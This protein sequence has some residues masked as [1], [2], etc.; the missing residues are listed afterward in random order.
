MDKPTKLSLA[1]IAAVIVAL[2]GGY[3]GA[4]FR[5]ADSASAATKAGSWI[6]DIKSRGELRVGVA[7]APP[8]TVE[9]NGVLGGP[10]LIPLQHLAKTLGVKLTPVPAT[11]GNIVAGLQAGRYDAAANLDATLERAKAIQFSDSVYEY[12]GV[13]VIAANSPYRTSKDVIAS[14]KQVAV[15][16]G[17]APA[18]AVKAAGAKILE[19]A[20]YTN[21]L[22]AVQANR[23]VAVFTDLPT[24]E[25][26]AQANAAYKILV[27]DPAIYAASA[28]YGLPDGIDPRSLQLLNV[29]I[30][31]SRLSGELERAYAGEKYVP[32]DQLGALEKK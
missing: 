25:S 21:A 5:G 11:W 7:I 19:L 10:N 16:Q 24:A 22:Q 15:A 14:G 32:I 3:F 9:K 20:D 13:F 28:S 17:S 18:A 8:M 26:Q 23:A 4:G 12:Q 6:E 27:P 29:A 31:T 2:V 1:A 30:N